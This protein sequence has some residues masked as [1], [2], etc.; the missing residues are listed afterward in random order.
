MDRYNTTDSLLPARQVCE[1]YKIVGQTLDRWLA[2]ERLNFPQPLI[3]NKR[4]Y[5][6]ERLLQ[7]W[8]RSRA[9]R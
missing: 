2:D 7:S 9:G 5:F 4:R 8:E 6:K 1:R 3:I